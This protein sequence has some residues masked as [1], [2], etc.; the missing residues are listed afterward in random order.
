MCSEL[1]LSQYRLV[2]N[3]L[4]S[5]AYSHPPCEMLKEHMDLL[6]KKQVSSSIQDIRTLGII[7]V[8]RVI[9]RLVWQ[10]GPASQEDLN[11]SFKT[12][13]DLP[14]EEGRVAANYIG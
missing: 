5:M 2:M 3:I 11:S 6:V 13:E 9:E 8:V 4:C 1:K 10:P 12:I 7:A 14:S